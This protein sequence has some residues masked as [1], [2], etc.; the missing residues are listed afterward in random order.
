MESTSTEEEKIAVTR[1]LIISS[2]EEEDAE[3]KKRKAGDLAWARKKRDAVE[4][5][6]DKWKM[7]ATM[8]DLVDGSYDEGYR[9]P[10][11]YEEW[12]RKMETDED[13]EKKETDLKP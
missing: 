13:G 12:Y 8:D 6:A 7:D 9:N 2:D 11:D 4:N 1:E 3:V 5:R 10:E